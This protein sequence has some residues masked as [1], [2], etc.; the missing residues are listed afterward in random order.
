MLPRIL[1]YNATILSISFRRLDVIFRLSKH[2]TLFNLQLKMAKDTMNKYYIFRKF[3]GK[4]LF[5]VGLNPSKA[6]S[7]IYRLIPHINILFH[8]YFSLGIIFFIQSNIKN[9]LAVISVSSVLVSQM[10][11]IM[12]V[13]WCIMYVFIRYK[14]IHSW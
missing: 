13:R 14:R 4:M 6:T 7:K 9:L 10:V 5:I 1:Q 12:K 2:L 8:A 11:S 3:I